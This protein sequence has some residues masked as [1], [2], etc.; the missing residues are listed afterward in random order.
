MT[1]VLRAVV[2]IDAACFDLNIVQRKSKG[3]RR[4][5][6]IRRGL[7]CEFLQQI[8]KVIGLVL[9]AN[10]GQIGRLHADVFEDGAA[11]DHR[12]GLKIEEQLLERDKGVR[13]A[14]IFEGQ[15]I[16][17]HREKKRVDVNV[18]DR[19]FAVK[20]LGQLLGQNGF[21]DWRQDEEAEQGID[22]DAG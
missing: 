11:F 16:D 15:S 5:L 18:A 22:A 3:L 1:R 14:A 21:Q 19:C 17:P 10:D 20:S 2:E 7:R 9:I 8:G 13:G 4:I 12:R 6:G